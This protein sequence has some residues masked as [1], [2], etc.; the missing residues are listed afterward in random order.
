MRALALAPP[1]KAALMQVQGPESKTR[2]SGSLAPTSDHPMILPVPTGS[3]PDI[4]PWKV[5]MTAGMPLAANA[6]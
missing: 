4:S 1:G 3:R 6:F 2:V 5:P